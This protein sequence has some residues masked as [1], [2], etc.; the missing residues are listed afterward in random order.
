MAFTIRIDEEKQ[1]KLDMLAQSMDRS[2]NWLVNEAIDNYLA[3]QAWQVEQIKLALLEAD[4][5]SN[6]ASDE[7][8][9]RLTNKY[10]NYQ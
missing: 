2:R 8:V 3:I 1:Q 7:E 4:D 10:K 9:A 5:E 6:F